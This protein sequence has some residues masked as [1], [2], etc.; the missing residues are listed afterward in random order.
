MRTPTVILRHPGYGIDN[1]L[2]TLP[3]VDG[4]TKTPPGL[5][6]RTV[7]TAGAII[8]D[9]AFDRVYLTRDRAGSVRVDTTLALDGLLEPGEYWLQLNG[10]ELFRDAQEDTRPIISSMPP[11]APPRPTSTSATQTRNPLPTSIPNA[12]ARAQSSTPPSSDSRPQTPPQHNTPYPI[13]PSFGD[14]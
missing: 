8:A 12:R 11:P 13:V 4:T 5:H 14:W 3:A 6:Q 10:Y 7:L 9:N 2:L 1:I